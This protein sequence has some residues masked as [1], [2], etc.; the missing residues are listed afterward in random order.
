MQERSD[1]LASC[2][3]NH[4]VPLSVCTAEELPRNPVEAAVATL[5]PLLQTILAEHG[6][7]E[8]A[9]YW[10]QVYESGRGLSFHFDKDEWMMANEQGM[11]NPVLSSVLYLT[12][13][14]ESPL[15]SPTVI[16]DQ[17]FDQKLNRPTPHNPT[18]SS[19]VFPLRNT[20]CLFDGRLGHGVVDS[21]NTD[22]RVTLLVNWWTNRPK[23]VQRHKKIEYRIHENAIESSTKAGSQ[24]MMHHANLHVSMLDV[25]PRDVDEEQGYATIDDVL[26]RR[27]IKPHPGTIVSIRHPGMSIYPVDAEQLQEASDDIS[28]E[29]GALLLPFVEDANQGYE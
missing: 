20:Y 11:V 24:K 5:F 6:E 23:L 2:D 22:K 4:W 8:G 27:D 14:I 15:Q 13:S 29:I 12:G 9:E 3:E 19:F 21:R 25:S 17:I 16:N 18:R 1:G 26:K 28:L 7:I 10:V